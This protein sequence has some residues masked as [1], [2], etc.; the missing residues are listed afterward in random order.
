MGYQAGSR[1]DDKHHSYLWSIWQQIRQKKKGRVRQMSGKKLHYE[2]SKQPRANLSGWWFLRS[3]F[4]F[5]FKRSPLSSFNLCPLF[6]SLQFA[7]LFGHILCS[8]STAV[9]VLCYYK[10]TCGWLWMMFAK[11]LLK[12]IHERQ[13]NNHICRVSQ[14]AFSFTNLQFAFVQW[15]FHFYYSLFLL[16]SSNPNSMHASANKN[17]EDVQ[18]VSSKGFWE[19]TLWVM[20]GHL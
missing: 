1:A 4:P 6:S 5:H 20:R 7:C 17:F 16:L 15:H 11:N 14:K 12:Q 18:H 9:S 13:K 2:P 10:F 8:N 19:S 3:W